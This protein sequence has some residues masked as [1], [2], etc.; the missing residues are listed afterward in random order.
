V[1]LAL[2]AI[3]V[4]AIAYRRHQRRR[5]SAAAAFVAAPMRASVAPTRPGWRRHFPMVAFAAALAVLIFAAARPQRSVAVP[6]TDG[7]V[8]LANDASSS[9]RATDVRPSRLGAAQRADANFLSHVPST[10]RVGLLEFNQ[11]ATLLQPPTS[12]RALTRAAIGRLRADGHTA[13][14]SA[15]QLATRL[16]SGLRSPSGRRVPGAIVLLSDGTS[17]SGPNALVAARQAA[18]AH[19]PVYTV[20][21]GT[22][23]GTISVPEG[24]K[25]TRKP[26]PL[27]PSELR[28]IATLSKA[29]SFTIGNSAGL[30]AVYAHLAARLGHKDVKREETASFAGAGLVLLLL[31]S[32]MS[33]RWFGRPA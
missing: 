16:L 14:G 12:D 28:Q 15:I 24:G 8:L 9:M 32:A 31:G 17:T 19:L 33:L 2:L 29:R 23:S 3:P 11:S 30:S 13:I 5:A 22:S 4:L 10:V 1:L 20:A 7:A 26:V 6:V 27:D 18:A 25:T 21:L